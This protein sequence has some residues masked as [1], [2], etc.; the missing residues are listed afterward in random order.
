[1]PNNRGPGANPG[2]HA[3]DESAHAPTGYAALL[4]TAEVAAVLGCD[5]S[6]VHR[7]HHAGLIAPALV[8]GP[9]KLWDLDAIRSALDAH[10][11]L[12]AHR[13]LRRAAR[14]RDHDPKMGKPGRSGY[15]RGCRCGA[16]T[17]ANAAYF[18]ARRNSR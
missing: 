15:V 9:M 16:C 5:Q 17:D 14:A 11:K 12:P 1:M 13:A 18:A 7:W 10:E 6:T 8:V 4:T 2:P 3:G